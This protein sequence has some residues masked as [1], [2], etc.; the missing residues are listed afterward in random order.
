MQTT[1]NTVVLVSLKRKLVEDGHYLGPVSKA[2]TELVAFRSYT[3]ILH[4]QSNQLT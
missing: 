3:G 2:H 1:T 4:G